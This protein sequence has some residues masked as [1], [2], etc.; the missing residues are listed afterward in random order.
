MERITIT[1]GQA[2]DL[3]SQMKWTKEPM[4]VVAPNGKRLAECTGDYIAAVEE[5]LAK[6]GAAMTGLN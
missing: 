6:M 3:L 2:I 1:E 5:A 4:D